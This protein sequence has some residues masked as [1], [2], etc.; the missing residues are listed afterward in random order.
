MKRSMNRRLAFTLLEVL[1]VLIIIGL[2]VGLVAPQIFGMREKANVDATRSQIGL[3]YNACDY[4]QI[5]MNDNPASLNQLVENPGVG[6]KWAGPY[7]KDG[8][9]PKDAWNQDFVY[10]PQP[11][12]TKPVIYSVGR[13]GQAGTADDV[14]LEETQ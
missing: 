5:T 6:S 2:L 3:I 14:H 7:L 11:A 13:D 4:F 10:E 1:L 12:G 8:R 9:L